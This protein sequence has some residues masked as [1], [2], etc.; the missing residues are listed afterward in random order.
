MPANLLVMP[1]INKPAATNKMINIS[2]RRKDIKIHREPPAKQGGSDP[3]Q[4]DKDGLQGQQT[5]SDSLYSELGRVSVLTHR[6]RSAFTAVCSHGWL[7]VLVALGGLIASEG[8]G[9]LVVLSC[10]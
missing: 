10:P 8:V 4:N 9:V 1:G 5:V 7:L 3:D 2:E 6:Q